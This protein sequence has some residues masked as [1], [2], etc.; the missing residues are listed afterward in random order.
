MITISPLKTDTETPIEPIAVNLQRAAALLD[1]SDR[2][3]WSL[4]K[5]GKIPH[6]RVG[7]RLL[8]SVEELRKFISSE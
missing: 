2:T 5:D 3:L 1:I 7:N 8:F 4:A 6:K